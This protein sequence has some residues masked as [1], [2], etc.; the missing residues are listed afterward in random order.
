MWQFC[1]ICRLYCDE[2]CVMFFVKHPATTEI[3]TYVHTLS[4]HDALPISAAEIERRL[5]AAPALA[6][7]FPRTELGR[8]L[9][10]AA[11]LIAAGVSASVLKLQHSGYDTHAQQAA[12][13]AALLGELAEGLAAF[14]R[15]L[16]IG[17]AHV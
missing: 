11:T 13:H 7:P 9:H 8:Q 15:A 3:Y 14:R 2:L 10:L 12:R 4:L 6:T 17:R 1:V 16:K 5:R